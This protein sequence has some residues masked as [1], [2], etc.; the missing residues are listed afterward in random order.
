MYFKYVF[1]LFVFQL[2]H[3]TTFGRHDL[4]W[5]DVREIGQ[6]NWLDKTIIVISSLNFNKVTDKMLLSEQQ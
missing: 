4:T 3:N 5:S 6:L 1:Q 2:L